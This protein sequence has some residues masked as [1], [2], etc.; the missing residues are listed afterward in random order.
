MPGILAV[1]NDCTP[2][3]RQHFETWYTREHLQER[4][5]VPGF[6]FGRRYELLTGGDRQFCAFLP[7]GRARRAQ[8]GRLYR[9]A[10]RPDALDT[11]GDDIVP[12]Q[13][14]HGLRGSRGGRDLI[15]AHAVILR[16]DEAMLPTAVA[17]EWVTE[18]ALQ[19]D[20]ARVELWTRAAQQTNPDTP[21]MKSRGADRLAAGVVLVE[22]LRRADA[23]GVMGELKG[24]PAA[25]GISGEGALGIYTLLCIYQPRR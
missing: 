14:A 13:G 19:E 23:D 25:L 8:L 2:E 4:V 7:G 10:Q 15:G 18:L 22:C 12:R 3:G 6:R 17:T 16:A 9:P 1:F 24:R 20:I 5:G 11:A 21:E